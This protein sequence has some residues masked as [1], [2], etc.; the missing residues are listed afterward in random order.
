M[1]KK[2]ILLFSLLLIL[3]L[4]TLANPNLPFQISKYKNS[5]E[6]K[7]PI[8]TLTPTA[9][10]TQFRQFEV[11]NISLLSQTQWAKEIEV[12]Y[13]STAQSS[14]TIKAEAVVNPE[15]NSKYKC[16]GSG[17][18]VGSGGNKPYTTKLWVL[19][20]YKIA[21]NINSKFIKF[22][23]W[24]NCTAI[25]PEPRIVYT[26]VAPFEIEWEAIDIQPHKNIA[27]FG[28]TDSLP[29]LILST[30]T[31]NFSLIADDLAK[32]GYP[33]AKLDLSADYPQ[34]VYQDDVILNYNLQPDGHL[35]LNLCEIL[36][37]NGTKVAFD[38]LYGMDHT[39]TIQ[40]SGV[41]A[42]T[43]P[44]INSEI[45]NNID[46]NGSD[47]SIYSALGLAWKS[48]EER[49][50]ENVKIAKT[51]LNSESSRHLNSAR[52]YLE[53]ASAFDVDLPELYIEYARY[54]MKSSEDFSEETK[55]DTG[56]YV[57]DLL[58]KA[59][60]RHPDHADLYVLLGYVEATQEDYVSAE[61]SLNKAKELG[62]NNW[63]LWANFG[64]LYENSGDTNK[65]I[66]MY[67]KLAN[68][69]NVSG[70]NVNAYGKAYWQ[71]TKLLQAQ[72]RFDEAEYFYLRHHELT[73]NLYSC[74]YRSHSR[75]LLEIENRFEDAIKWANIST[76]NGCKADIELSEA[77]YQKWFHSLLS[78]ENTST[79][80]KAKLATQNQAQVLYRIASRKS[81]KVFLEDLERNSENINVVSEGTTPLIYAVRY[82]N[83]E[84]A[85]N[86]LAV[87]ANSNYS[88]PPPNVSA[89]AL[90]VIDQQLE[91]IDLL[92]EHGADPEKQTPYGI[93]ILE[94]ARQMGQDDVVNKLISRGRKVAI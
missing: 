21:E 46:K 12:T 17:P 27:E 16:L 70:S 78:E 41:Y 90:A 44:Y 15:S 24:Q 53:R 91:M 30:T 11:L 23:L 32:W 7:A 86:L 61:N 68:F 79:L 88:P 85:K 58:R 69:E 8:P 80:A 92:L 74:L 67:S 50:R 71:L 57:M 63:W 94:M 33:L 73:P 87:G 60:A 65:A 2:I 75:M 42:S 19:R 52:E 84:A 31:K 89:L 20:P 9:G 37:E 14:L 59:T 62:T 26:E 25:K 83:L 18:R 1:T 64:R 5:R 28:D 93:S 76:E 34:E 66:E 56:A 77:Y 4:I 47:E 55:S 3:A 43:L 22:N 49:A 82:K 29:N 39:P 13:R 48:K 10:T 35:L 72:N 54:Y 36:I 38:K 6:P 81:G 51:Y 45:L 40:L